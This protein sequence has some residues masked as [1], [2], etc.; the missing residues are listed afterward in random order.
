MSTPELAHDREVV[1]RP[2]LIHLE[3]RN[4]AIFVRSQFDAAVYY[5][6][7]A[8]LGGG[9]ATDVRMFKKNFETWV[10]TSGGGR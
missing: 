1:L 5:R 3:W 4:G 7:C 2:S 10:D 9:F 6:S 8:G